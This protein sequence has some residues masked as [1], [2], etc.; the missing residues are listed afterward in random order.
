MKEKY[1]IITVDTEWENLLISKGKF[2]QV[3]IGD[4][5]KC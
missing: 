4:T 5:F 3:N 2:I 1:S